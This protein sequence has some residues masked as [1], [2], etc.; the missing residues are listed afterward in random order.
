MI[1]QN[2]GR[3]PSRSGD[4]RDHVRGGKPGTI[5]GGAPT[6]WYKCLV[7]EIKDFRSRERSTERSPLQFGVETLPWV[8]TYSK[9]CGQA[10]PGIAQNKKR[11][12]VL[13]VRWHEDMANKSTTRHASANWGVQGKVGLGGGQ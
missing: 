5:L 7:G 2:E 4:V 13:V 9:E 11:K 1:W 12:T 8:T 10:V 6:G 3:S